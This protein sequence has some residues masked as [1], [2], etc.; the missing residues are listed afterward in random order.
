MKSLILEKEYIEGLSYLE[1]KKHLNKTRLLKQIYVH[2]PKSSVEL[3]VNLNISLPT[4]LALI[5]EMLGEG[6]LEKKG[7]GISVGGRKPDLHSLRAGSIYVLSIEIGRFETKMCI[8]DNNHN[9][10]TGVQVFNLKITTN[11]AALKQLVVLTEDFI[12][13]S[14]V[15]PANLVGVGLSMPGLVDPKKGNNYSYLYEAGASSTLREELESQLKKPVFIQHDVKS[16][17]MAECRRGIAKGKQNVLVV[18]LDWGIGLGAIVDGKICTGSTGFFGEIGHIP[19]V[20]NGDL[21]YCGKRGCLETVASGVAIARKAKEAIKSGKDSILNQL[22]ASDLENIEPKQ[23][24]E[25]ANRGD[26]FAIELL[27]EFGTHLGKGLSTLIQLFNPELI[28]LGGIM[29]EA[30]QYLTIPTRQAINTYCMTELREQVAIAVSDIG[31]HSVIFGA[32]YT[33]FENVIDA[34]IQLMMVDKLS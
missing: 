24:I 23:I 13:R 5:N 16:S 6:L 19:F 9:N 34:Q 15:D 10:I 25:A 20:D 21:C 7:K 1:K 18:L 22:A 8:L 27:S 2:G 29:A 3:A 32:A 28:I 33:V 14:G 17:T 12:E 30:K 26:Q 31:P 4:S 11:R